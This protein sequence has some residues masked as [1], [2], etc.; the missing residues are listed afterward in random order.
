MIPNECENVLFNLTAKEKTALIRVSVDH[1]T[2]DEKVFTLT[3][4]LY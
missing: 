1:F 4:K 2:I 3:G